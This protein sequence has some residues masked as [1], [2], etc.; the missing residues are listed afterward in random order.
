M[1]CLTIF[2]FLPCGMGML[3]AVLCNRILPVVGL[4]IMSPTLAWE[5]TLVPY[6]TAFT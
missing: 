6:E 1:W 4:I 5:K 3:G 2:S